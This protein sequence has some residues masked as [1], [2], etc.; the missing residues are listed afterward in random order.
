MLKCQVIITSSWQSRDP[1]R[2]EPNET[3]Y[4]MYT[5]SES[6]SRNIHWRLQ[7]SPS[8]AERDSKVHIV[9]LASNLPIGL[10]RIIECG[11]AISASAISTRAV[12]SIE[13]AEAGSDGERVRRNERNIRAGAAARGCRVSQGGLNESAVLSVEAASA[14]LQVRD[15]GDE[16]SIRSEVTTSGQ[17]V[18]ILNESGS[19]KATV[20]SEVDSVRLSTDGN[21]GGEDDSSG[22]GEAQ[23]RSRDLLEH[24]WD[25]W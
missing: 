23:H 4:Y 1:S 13:V 12:A 15:D 6:R 17:N 18:S 22:A 20:V 3:S 7:P 24:R 16:G 8:V 9:N 19:P 2:D 5:V 11:V 25:R 21:D 10:T 14:C